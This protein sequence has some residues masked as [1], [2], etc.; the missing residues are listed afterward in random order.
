MLNG[1]EAIKAKLNKSLFYSQIA[2]NERF[3]MSKKCRN[4]IYKSKSEDP[5]SPLAICGGDTP[6][7]AWHC[8]MFSL[9]SQNRDHGIYHSC[10]L[11]LF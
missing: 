7:V 11:L 5:A 1:Q 6:S 4:S 9:C 3:F 8:W 2:L 10:Q